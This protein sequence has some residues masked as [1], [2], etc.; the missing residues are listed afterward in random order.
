MEGLNLDG[1]IYNQYGEVNALQEAATVKIIR[2][3]AH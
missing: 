1:G 2:R 3:K